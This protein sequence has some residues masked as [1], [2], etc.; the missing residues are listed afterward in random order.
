MDHPALEQNERSRPI[1]LNMLPVL[2]E[3]LRQRNVTHAAA[4]LNMSQSAVSDALARLR[5]AFDDELL[6]VSGRGFVLSEK[7][8]A[9]E[10]LLSGA[11][12]GMEVMLNATAF[13]PGKAQGRVHIATSDYVALTL[14][15]RLVRAI[16]DVAP[17]VCVQFHDA[18]EESITALSVGHLDFML[19]P[20]EALGQLPND[21]EKAFIFD[22]QLVVT[23]S[24]DAENPAFATNHDWSG[25]DA[26]VGAALSS[27][28]TSRPAIRQHLGEGERETI[29]LPAF[30]LLPFFA[31]RTNIVTLVQRRLAE[32]LAPAAGTKMIAPPFPVP[33]V[34]VAAAWKRSRNGDPFHRWLSGL[35]FDIGAA[36][37]DEQHQE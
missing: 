6:V 21:I 12:E 9:L 4:T 29:A 10:P 20:E 27:A 24:A 30:M 18:D 31:G 13:D 11:L 7:A 3:L 34:R 2:R 28:T 23:T 1:N 32:R 26:L 33:A 5:Q 25:P 19:V 15:T 36:M 8:E 22:D 35:I 37:R 14:G 17:N 16:R